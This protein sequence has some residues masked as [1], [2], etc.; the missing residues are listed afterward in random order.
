[1][2]QAKDIEKK[3]NLIEQEIGQASKQCL[4]ISDAS[5]QLKECFTR[6]NKQSLVVKQAVQAHDE[7]RILKSIDELEMLGGE[8]EKACIRD[9]HVT[10]DIKDS[11]WKMHHDLSDLKQQLH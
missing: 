4:S 9:S 2:L 8:A 6:L 3:F 10:K 1:M 11:V 7:A 5:P